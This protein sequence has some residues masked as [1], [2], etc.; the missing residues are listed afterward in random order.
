[1]TAVGVKGGRFLEAARIT[2]A[3][4]SFRIG[5]RSGLLYLSMRT[6]VLLLL[7]DTK[8]IANWFLVWPLSNFNEKLIS[9]PTEF[10]WDP[11]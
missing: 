5:L 1:M 11:H 9:K 4:I 7:L 6:E 8:L 10:Q 2:E 3:K